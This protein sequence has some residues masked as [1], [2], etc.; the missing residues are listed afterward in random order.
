[1]NQLLKLGQTITG[2]TSGLTAQIDGFLGG[3]GERS[4]R[5]RSTA[6]NWRQM[7]LPALP[8]R[9][10]P[11]ERL[12]RTGAGATTALWPSEL[13]AA[14]GVSGFG[15]I[16]TARERSR[17]WL[18]LWRV[19]SSRPSAPGHCRLELAPPICSFTPAAS[20]R[21]ISFGN[22]FDPA[23]G[24]VR[25]CDNDN[26]HRRSTRHDRRHR[27]SWPQ[28]VTGLARPARKPI[29]A[30]RIVSLSVAQP[31]PLEGSLRPLSAAST[32]RP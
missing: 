26:R 20:Y 14:P 24:E 17:E 31:S 1:M 21:D 12:E 23:T 18:T 28:T 2:E 13:A 3:G 5:A 7:V 6:N 4:Y 16:M 27:P 19:A 29:F 25:I 30:C 8:A 11:G 10:P 15:Y 9:R 32:C 22:V